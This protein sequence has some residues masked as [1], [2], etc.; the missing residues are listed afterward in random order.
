[1]RERLSPR[2]ADPPLCWC[3]RALSGETAAHQKAMKKCRRNLA[4]ADLLSSNMR[5]YPIV[6]INSLTVKLG[7]LG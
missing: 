7:E 5:V 4:N 1:M 3:E 6:G 2:R